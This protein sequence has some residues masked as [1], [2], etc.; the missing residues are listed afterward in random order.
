M[1]STDNKKRELSRNDPCPCGSGKKFKHCCLLRKQP[2][3]RWQFRLVAGVWLVASAVLALLMRDA[4][5]LM[6][7]VLGSV[8]SLIL[9]LRA[10]RVGRFT[11]EE[12]LLAVSALAPDTES[13]YI[14]FVGGGR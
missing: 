9:G 10:K 7:G 12:G 1:K 11:P 2:V 3:F 4:A 6:V 5:I 14:D 8:V 13:D